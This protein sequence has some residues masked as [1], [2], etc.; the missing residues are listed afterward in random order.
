[1]CPD[2]CRGRHNKHPDGLRS[3]QTERNKYFLH[4]YFVHLKLDF[5]KTLTFQCSLSVQ[6]KKTQI[7]VELFEAEHARAVGIFETCGYKAR[8]A[9][10]GDML[11][12]I[13]IVKSKAPLTS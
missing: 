8:G 2:P 3:S 4:V 6:T 1:M 9:Q 13:H 7:M 12:T 10:K 5:L 11:L